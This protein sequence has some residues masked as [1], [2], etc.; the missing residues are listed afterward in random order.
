M[1]KFIA[2]TVFGLALAL[3][4]TVLGS[5]ALEKIDAYLRP[6]FN[7]SLDGLKLELNNTPVIVDGSMYLPL[8]ETANI[9]GVDVE[10]NSETQTAELSSKESQQDEKNQ[11]QG[12]KV[13]NNIDQEK[14]DDKQVSNENSKVKNAKP[15]GK[16]PKH[17]FNDVYQYDGKDYLTVNEIMSKVKGIYVLPNIEKNTLYLS[18][19]EFDG[20]V[21]IENIPYV[22]FD[23]QRRIDYDFY[24]KNILPLSK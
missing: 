8:K 4:V 9:V 24:V 7:V 3:P 11:Q 10:W 16:E 2:G 17:G 13:N 20:E 15:D 1:K 6:D 5:S 12:S 21:L 23:L 18:D 14:D 19:K 22:E